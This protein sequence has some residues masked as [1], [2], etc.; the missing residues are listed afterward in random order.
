MELVLGRVFA[1]HVLY[2]WQ[3]QVNMNCV[4]ICTSGHC[5]AHGPV[6]AYVRRI[7]NYRVGSG[8]ITLVNNIARLCS[9]S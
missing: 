9:K 7:Y 8:D 4:Y 6:H 1:H 3:W 5:S 2:A